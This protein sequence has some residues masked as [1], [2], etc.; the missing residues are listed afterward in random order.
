M[1]RR[2][3][4]REHALQMLFQIDVTGAPPDE[5]FR[6]FWSDQPVDAGTREFSES[7]VL[8]VITDRPALDE[9]I[10]GSTAHWR[11]ERMAVVDRNVLRMAGHELRQRPAVPAAV[12]IDEAIE[13]AKKFGGEDSGAFVNGIL[14]TIRRRI[15]AES[16]A[17]R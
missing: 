9:W 1:G 4:A 12:I 13:V 6:E 3:Q 8:G 5:V 2:R 15:E 11:I 7:L 10:R 14:D 17:D 16:G